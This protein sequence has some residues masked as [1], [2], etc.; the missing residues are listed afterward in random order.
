MGN[1]YFEKNDF[2]DALECFKIAFAL[3]PNN[4]IISNSVGF[5]HYKMKNFTA[6]KAAFEFTLS[7]DKNN[8][9]AKRKLSDILRLNGDYLSGLRLYYDTTGKIIF[10][11]KEKVTIHKYN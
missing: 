7:I 2:H 4:C 9:P 11:D 5:L 8:E 3:S 6:S 10:T 1:V